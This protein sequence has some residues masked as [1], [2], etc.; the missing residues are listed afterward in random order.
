MT[1]IGTV[2][3]R[4]FKLICVET[5]TVLLRIAVSLSACHNNTGL[6]IAANCS[7]LSVLTLNS[8]SITS[9][10]RTVSPK[11]MRIFEKYSLTWLAFKWQKCSYLIT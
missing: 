3:E 1:V 10:K 2:R 8:V 4:C 6:E 7:K 11:R 9:I 5:T